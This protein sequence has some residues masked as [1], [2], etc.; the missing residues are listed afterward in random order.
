MRSL[1]LGRKITAAS[2]S[3]SPAFTPNWLRSGKRASSAAWSPACQHH[4]WAL[5]RRPS[6]SSAGKPHQQ[7]I[8]LKKFGLTAFTARIH[9][10]LLEKGRS[11]STDDAQRG[12]AEKAQG[13]FRQL[14]DDA[15]P[16]FATAP[17]VVWCDDNPAKLQHAP[18]PE[19]K[20]TFTIDLGFDATDLSSDIAAPAKKQR[21]TPESRCHANVTRRR[22]NRRQLI[23]L[24]PSASTLI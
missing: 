23:P 3:R 1:D 17:G 5:G 22:R 10:L 12:A 15:L 9:G 20:E 21:A 14:A 4:P 6:R 11:L 24:E 2:N 16:R 13:V 18:L 8:A 7:Q 19:A